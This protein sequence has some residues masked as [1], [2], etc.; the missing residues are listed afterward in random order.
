MSVRASVTCM[1][2]FPASS[3]LSTLSE[4]CLCLVQNNV[5]IAITSKL[6]NRSA[7]NLNWKAAIDPDLAGSDCFTEHK[8]DALGAGRQQGKGTWTVLQPGMV[9]IAPV[10]AL[11]LRVN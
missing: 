2:P 5:M 9:H 6:A 8:P 7:R 4:V 11:M 3:F 1:L 10:H